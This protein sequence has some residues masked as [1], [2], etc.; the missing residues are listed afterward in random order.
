MATDFLLHGHEYMYDLDW[1]VKVVKRH[2][3]ELAQIDQKIADAIKIWLTDERIQNIVEDIISNASGMVNVKIPPAELTPATGDGSANDTAAI[4]GCIDYVHEKGYG[5][6]F[7]PAGKYLVNDLTLYDDIGIVGMGRYTTTLT[8]SGGSANHILG[9]AASH[10]SICQI[11]LNGNMSNQVDNIDGIRLTGDDF[12]FE[13]LL[14][15]QCYEGIN[16][17]MQHGP[18]QAT[19]IL[20]DRM[21]LSGVTLI[22]GHDAVFKD[23][24]INNISSTTGQHAIECQ[25]YDSSFT[26]VH[27]NSVIPVG[28]VC[29]ADS[30]VF[31][32]WIT[33]ISTPYQDTGNNNK[34]TLPGVS[35]KETTETKTLNVTSTE[36]NGENVK[37]NLTDSIWYKTPTHANAYDT[38]PMRS[39]EGNPYNVMVE[40]DKTMSWAR[41]ARQNVKYYGAKGDGI[42]DDT[43]AFIDCAN[44]SNVIYIPTGN[45]IIKGELDWSNKTVIG[46]K[47]TEQI[48]GRRDLNGT[49]LQI[50]Q[51]VQTS[52]TDISNCSFYY[53]LIE[54][55]YGE[56][57]L[58]KGGELTLEK[59]K[60]AGYGCLNEEYI[61]GLLVRHCIIYQCK[62]GINTIVDGRIIDSSITACGTGIRLGNGGSANTIV[63]NRIEWSNQGGY[64]I[65]LVDCAHTNVNSNQ[66][67]HNGDYNIYALRCTESTFVGN[68]IN[69]CAIENEHYEN[70]ETCVISNVN[71]KGYETDQGGNLQPDV[72]YNFTNNTRLIVNSVF[73]EGMRVDHYG[74]NNQ[75]VMNV[76]PG[77]YQ[78]LA[79]SPQWRSPYGE[80]VVMGIPVLSQY[81]GSTLILIIT[82]SKGSYNIKHRI[83][84]WNVDLNESSIIMGE[85]DSTIENLTVEVSDDKRYATFTLTTTEAV[86]NWNLRYI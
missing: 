50:A 20:I 29:G 72:A 1:L 19:D 14:I 86:I 54:W 74:T 67:D 22:G 73:T 31:E 57:I 66:F 59:C 63:G 11:G 23:L 37:V 33:G 81:Y 48:G 78:D 28:F 69:R 36:I 61:L 18:V 8:A 43:Q 32:G 12:L 2:S 13:G 15:E 16:L 25:A 55:N 51:T 79:P 49:V 47:M 7:F 21:G 82:T 44:H 52:K 17:T 40:N 3:D 10:V 53:S 5:V 56:T 65:Y 75:S 42:T 77:E 38:I 70:C 46:E 24:W 4:Q 39:D 84:Y 80:P 9:G 85:G 71:C 6:V 41:E 64:G 83:A 30:C 68:Y 27:I 76:M 26:N 35:S 58:F 34:I 60:I 62:I 45:Y